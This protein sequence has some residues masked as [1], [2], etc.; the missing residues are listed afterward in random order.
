MLELQ[1]SKIG[2]RDNSYKRFLLEEKQ[3]TN[4]QKRFSVSALQGSA[5]AATPLSRQN[6]G[7]QSVISSGS[8]RSSDKTGTNRLLLPKGSDWYI[9]RQNPRGDGGVSPAPNSGFSGFPEAISSGNRRSSGKTGTNPLLL[10]RGSD[11]YITWPDP[12]GDQKVSFLNPGF[13]EENPG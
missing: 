2:L 12:S 4:K 7:I 3:R 13:L 10:P 5:T 8:R 6:P 9:T 11:W 1:I